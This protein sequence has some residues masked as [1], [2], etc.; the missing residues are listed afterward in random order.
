MEC[1]RVDPGLW[2]DPHPAFK[3][4]GQIRN[5]FRRIEADGVCE[6]EEFHDIDPSF[7]PFDPRDVGLPPIQSVGEGRLSEIRVFPRL[8]QQFA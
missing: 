3:K 8:P 1:L 7:T 2:A 5:E 4:L 6:V